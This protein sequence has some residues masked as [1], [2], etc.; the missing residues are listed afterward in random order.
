MDSSSINHPAVPTPGFSGEPST[1]R[2]TA[3]RRVSTK[4]TV[5]ATDANGKS[6][7]YDLSKLA[8]QERFL[9][10]LSV[11]MHRK[12]K[13]LRPQLK[14][15]KQL[16]HDK[17]RGTT[18]C[19][20]ASVGEYCE[21]K[22]HITRQAFYAE[23]SDYRG[24]QKAKGQGQATKIKRDP[25][26][27]YTEHERQLLNHAGAAGAQLVEALKSGDLDAQ[28]KATEEITMVSSDPKL[29]NELFADHGIREE[30]LSTKLRV[31][32]LETRCAE[33]EKL[34]KKRAKVEK[35]MLKL[36]EQIMKADQYQPLPADLMR[37]AA[38]LRTE[39]KVDADSLGLVS[40][41]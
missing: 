16:F 30:V 7:S 33:L 29:R 27:H 15:V 10:N 9:N 35:L 26:K 4:L 32:K 2:P 6:V 12:L 18:L 13:E 24:K 17:P 22:L 37:V 39:M 19:G 23:V 40:V 20:C 36:L 31:A 3:A 14:Y 5:V 38:T 8:D 11:V 34:E 28:R 25:P 21:Q 1:A 41:Q